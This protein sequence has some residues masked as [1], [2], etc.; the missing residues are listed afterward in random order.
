M[1]GLKRSDVNINNHSVFTFEIFRYLPQV[2]T[3]PAAS[4]ILEIAGFKDAPS[5][6]KDADFCSGDDPVVFSD[7]VMVLFT[8]LADNGIT[9][10]EDRTVSVN[11]RFN[12]KRRSES[13]DRCL[14]VSNL[15]C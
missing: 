11:I 8:R 5:F 15:D 3:A 6:I 14:V 7:E 4:A 12:Q 2:L 9:Y 10:R 1:S 13:D